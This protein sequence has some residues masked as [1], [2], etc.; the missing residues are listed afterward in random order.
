MGLCAFDEPLRPSVLRGIEYLIRTQN[1]DGSWTE[2]ET[3]GTGFPKVF[4]L[5]YDMYRNAWP[6]L[7]LATY[8]G[9][10]QKKSVSRDTE[11]NG[12]PVDRAVGR[13]ARQGT[14]AATTAE[15]R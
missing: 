13:G 14:L 1:V 12:K 3:T 7:A 8:R 11:L 5:K 2:E 6:L 9:L 4:Y 10:L 15:R